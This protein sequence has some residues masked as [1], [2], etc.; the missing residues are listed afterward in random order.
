MNNQA[1]AVIDYGAGNL[2]SVLNAIAKLGYQAVVTNNPDDLLNAAAVILP[3]VGA[4]GDTMY[5]LEKLGISNVL[6][7]L[8]D[9]RRPFFAVCVGL[10]VLFSG[11]EES[12]WH[13]CL[14]VIPGIV[15]RLPLGLKIPHM[16]WNQVKQ[17]ITHPLF[18]GIPDE[19]NFYFVH[20]YYAEPQDTSVVAGTTDY[21]KS[22]CS[23][24]IRDNLVATQF[25]PEKSGD[26]GLRLYSNFLGRALS[27]R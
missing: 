11:T 19:A 2:R 18:E 12:G 21:G 20:S 16:G 6:L 22:I 17:M 1:V 25:H 8:I 15:K 26:Y 24:V 13:K 27:E 14:D 3:G 7:Q 9:E 23:V 10:Q 4:A 5:S